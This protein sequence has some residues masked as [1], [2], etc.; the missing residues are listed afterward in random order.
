MEIKVYRSKSD[1]GQLMRKVHRLINSHKSFELYSPLTDTKFCEFISVD[2]YYLFRKDNVTVAFDKLKGSKY[3]TEVG[4]N[5]LRLDLYNND[6]N[7]SRAFVW[8]SQLSIR[9]ISS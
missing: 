6:A 7:I 4:E 5:Y 3:S 8:W 9:I 2:G 1:S